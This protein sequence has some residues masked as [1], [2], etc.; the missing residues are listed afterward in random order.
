MAAPLKAGIPAGLDLDANYTIQ[1]AALSPVDGS[2]VTGVSVSNA[3]LLVTNVSGG[4][5][6]SGLAD[7]EPLWIPIPNADLN[8]PD[9]G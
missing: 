8:N 5:L 9:G 3:S 7:E 2:A 6:S 1:F 4:D